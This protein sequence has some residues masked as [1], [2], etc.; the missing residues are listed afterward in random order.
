MD[1]KAYSRR[2]L[3][4]L[5]APADPAWAQLGDP[6]GLPLS[7][8]LDDMA[9]RGSDRLFLC[10]SLAQMSREYVE[11]PLSHGWEFA[12]SYVHKYRSPVYRHVGKFDWQNH[13][14]YVAEIEQRCELQKVGNINIKLFSE[15]WC[16]GCEDSMVATPAWRALK[17]EWKKSTGLP[18][19]TTPAATGRA[20]LW[21]TLP[22]GHSFPALP[23]DVA[24]LVR[25][26]SPQHRIE[27]VQDGPPMSSEAERTWPYQYDGRW[28]YAA[29]CSVDRFPVGEPRPVEPG[30]YVPY[31]PGWYRCWIEIP[32][33]WDHIGLI[34]YPREDG[35]WG[36]PFE[37]GLVFEVWASEPELTLAFH[38]Q[39]K[40]QVIEGWRFEKGRPLEAWADMLIA[41][42]QRLLDR[43]FQACGNHFQYAAAAVRNIL[44][45]TI[46][47]LHVDG[48]EREQ[49]VSNADWLAWVKDNEHLLATREWKRVE[50]G[51]LCPVIVPNESKMSI[52]M[53][54]WSATVW[55]LER[56]R[57]AQWALRC[58][59]RSL[60][61]ING[62]AIYSTAPLP[63]EDNGN[64]GQLRR[65]LQ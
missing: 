22:K 16:E 62:D 39:W 43:D 13:S 6:E 8:I 19:L 10:G 60:V 15:S 27:F 48:Y 38:Q 11:E 24:K 50:G 54:H 14:E 49:F 32:E 37:P 61:K 57:V 7:G 30:A 29:M 2:K 45:H 59:P 21:E 9:R 55:A 64:L 58:D 12:R 65:K 47:S 51:R 52:Y 28:M 20:L 23:D 44:N 3:H 34:P 35:G 42:R 18:L 46:G 17:A 56:A 63:F 41:M 31:R 4:G 26:K 25:R 36:Y 33:T 5:K 53:P 1:K 40:I